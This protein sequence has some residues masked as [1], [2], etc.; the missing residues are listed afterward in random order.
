MTGGTAGYT[1]N[2][3][4]RGRLGLRPGSYADYGVARGHLYDSQ[5]TKGPGLKVVAG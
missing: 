1:N 3:K 2:K 5:V 4:Y